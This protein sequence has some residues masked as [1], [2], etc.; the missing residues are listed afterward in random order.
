MDAAGT[1]FDDVARRLAEELGAP[2]GDGEGG[3][4]GADKAAAAAAT[5][6]VTVGPGNG[7]LMR[8]AMK[9]PASNQ[10]RGGVGE[11]WGA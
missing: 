11:R 7:G 10:V 2:A 8:V 4:E 1:D 3:A 6:N 5:E 9:H